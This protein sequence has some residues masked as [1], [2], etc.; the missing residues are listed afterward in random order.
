MGRYLTKARPQS[1]GLENQG[2]LAPCR[3]TGCSLWCHAD[4]EHAVASTGGFAPSSVRGFRSWVFLAVSCEAPG[5]CRPLPS[6]TPA[7]F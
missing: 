3:S 7:A 6:C 4:A 5:L 1:R 2:L